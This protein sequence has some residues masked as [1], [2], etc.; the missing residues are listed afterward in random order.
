MAR[1]LLWFIICACCCTIAF[2]ALGYSLYLR[3]QS[4][5]TIGRLRSEVDRLCKRNEALAFKN[6]ELLSQWAASHS[7]KMAVLLLKAKVDRRLIEL[8]GEIRRL[9][10]ANESLSKQNWKTY[11]VDEHGVVIPLDPQTKPNPES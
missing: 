6:G 9:G 3:R 7:E 10:L 4:L 5:K 2:C 8:C 1:D 11:I